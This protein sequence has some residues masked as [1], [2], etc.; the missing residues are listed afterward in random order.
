VGKRGLGMHAESLLQACG[1]SWKSTLMMASQLIKRG[2]D[3]V[4]IFSTKLGR[5]P[6]IAIHCELLTDPKF[7]FLSLERK[8]LHQSFFVWLLEEKVD[9]WVPKFVLFVFSDFHIASSLMGLKMVRVKYR[10]HK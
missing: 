5:S 10:V 4:S 7:P 6:I 8:S 2:V 1:I 3:S 9:V